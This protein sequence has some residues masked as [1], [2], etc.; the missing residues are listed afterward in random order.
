MSTLLIDLGNTALK[1]ALTDDPEQARTFVHH[2]RDHLPDEL[3]QQWLRLK[4]KNILGCIVGSENVAFAATQF[5]NLHGFRWIWLKAEKQ[6]RGSFILNNCY[7][8]VRQLGADRWFAAIG[9]ASLY[10]RQA[11]LVMH[12]GTA[13][14]VDALVPNGEEVDFLGGRILPGPTMMLDALLEHTGCR[15]GGTGL[16]NFGSSSRR[17]RELKASGGRTWLYSSFGVCW[18]RRALIGSVYFEALSPCGFKAQPSF[19][20]AGG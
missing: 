15:P 19:A 7:D 14:T 4:P 17:D 9:A 16:P 12:M 6:F 2:G 11:V 10:P 5:F 8:S 3:Q 13:T 1:W 20:R 18:R